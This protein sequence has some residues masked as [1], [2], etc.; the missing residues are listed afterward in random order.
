[1]GCLQRRM[2]VCRRLMGELMRCKRWSMLGWN[3]ERVLILKVMGRES[4][5]I[6]AMDVLTARCGLTSVHASLRSG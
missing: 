6:E 4:M 1:M 3:G 2:L 5:R